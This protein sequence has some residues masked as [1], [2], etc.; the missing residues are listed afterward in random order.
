MDPIRGRQIVT[1]LVSM[2]LEE[3]TRNGRLNLLELQETLLSRYGTDTVRLLQWGDA[4][5]LDQRYFNTGGLHLRSFYGWPQIGDVV[6][7]FGIDMVVTA[8]GLLTF[9]ARALRV[10]EESEQESTSEKEDEGDRL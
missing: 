6:C 10:E 9:Q 3:R 8:M 7:I 5:M 4:R 2:F 1:P